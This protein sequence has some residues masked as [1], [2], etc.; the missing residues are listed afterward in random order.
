MN[1][2]ILFV[3]RKSLFSEVESGFT[4]Y[5]LYCALWFSLN[6]YFCLF[7]RCG[8]LGCDFSCETCL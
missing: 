7:D 5:L 2:N 6:S 8:L 1:L 4:P 3:K